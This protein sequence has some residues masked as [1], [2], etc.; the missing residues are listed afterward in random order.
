M[1]EGDSMIGLQGEETMIID[2]KVIPVGT[3]VV[4]NLS[5][6]LKPEETSPDPTPEET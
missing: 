3:F 6:A 5:R 2:R 4:S 1:E